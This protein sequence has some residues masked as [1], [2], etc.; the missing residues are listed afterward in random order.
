[1]IVLDH[2]I[3]CVI[4]NSNPLFWLCCSLV[5]TSLDLHLRTAGS[6]YCRLH[7]GK[8][9]YTGVIRAFLIKTAVHPETQTVFNKDGKM[10]FRP[11][12]NIELESSQSLPL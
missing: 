2:G 5:L 6:C 8:K 7:A 4:L 3:G 10:L 9:L 1:M 11:M 12:G